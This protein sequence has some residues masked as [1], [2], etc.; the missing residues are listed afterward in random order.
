MKQ[1]IAY[2]VII[3]FFIS[4][5]AVAQVNSVQPVLEPATFVG[6]AAGSSQLIAQSSATKQRKAKKSRKKRSSRRKSSRLKKSGDGDL[7]KAFKLARDGQYQEAS[8]ILFRLSHQAR[9]EK[10]KVKIKYT[11][12]LVLYQMGLNQV[13]A[14]QFVNVIKSKNKKYL[15]KAL[16]QLSLASDKIGD[17]SLLNYAI[18]KVNI[19]RFPKKHKDMLYYRIGEFQMRN[20]QMAEAAKSLGRVS[21]SSPF[22]NQAKYLQGL[23]YSENNQ[24]DKA[25]RAFDQLVKAQVSNDVT[26]PNR[27][28]GIM[29]RARAYYQGEKWDKAIAN[30]R[31]IPKDSEFWHDTLFE[32]SWAM[33]RSGRFRSVLS[34]FQSLHSPYYEEFYIPESLLLRSI[35]YLYICKYEE[36]DKVLGIFN[37]TYKPIGLKMSQYLASNKDP[38]RYFNDVVMALEDYKELGSAVLKKHYELPFQVARKIL[39]DGKF[40]RSYKYIKGL[41][42]EQK[43]IQAMSQ[44]WRVS[45]MGQYSEKVI[46]KRIAKARIK[47]G[48]EVRA[49][50]ISM[51]RELEEL[52]EQERFIN[53]EKSN[54]IRESLKK[55]AAKQNL[56]GGQI[57]K[58]KSRSFYIKD[59]FEYWPFKGEYWLDEVGNYHYVGTHSCGS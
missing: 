17:D 2:M 44:K 20:R 37:K 43:K 16:G 28:L 56:D 59:G 21:P 14:F 22:Y 42:K 10:E 7:V 4:T 36:M 19:D 8:L 26:H 46:S 35:V 18:S 45:A 13:S 5:L 58:G 24:I 54:S 27:V 25:V 52:F 41:R 50:I 39:K 57:D 55:V 11:L 31:A 38:E 32:S 30:Y 15:N 3:S 33:L 53:F 48:R 47:I 1:A 29:G 49:Q 40:Q 9:Y 34:N 51:N 12:G 6:K 23:S